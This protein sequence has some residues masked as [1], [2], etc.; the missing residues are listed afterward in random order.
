MT[1]KPLSHRLLREPLVHFLILGVIV[2]GLHSFFAARAAQADQTIEIS[3][4]Q[5]DRLK[6]IWSAEV[7]TDPTADDVKALISEFV[8]EEV[9]YREALRLGLDRDDTIL[10]RRL[11]QKMGFLI[12]RSGPPAPLSLEELETA[13]NAD[14]EAYTRPTRLSFVQIPFNFQGED[15][16][17]SEDIADALAGLQD[18][19]PETWAEFGD[20]FLL[21]RNHEGLTQTDI[22]RLFGQD[23]AAR[24]FET[25]VQN[26]WVGPL[27]SRLANHL[28]RIT[29][30]QVA[31]L[32]PFQDVV[33]EVRARETEARRRVSNETEL[34]ALI[35]QYTVILTGEPS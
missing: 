19:A 14:P 5:L 17:R 22:A 25:E 28:V 23:F 32:P 15:R 9:L 16:T 7:G 18:A 6:T 24:I 27:R 35:S 13:Y 12:E 8:R 10:R 34:D 33:E 11:A 20:P 1:K 3:A 31:S 26:S 30:R 29:D 2:F 4:S 21:S